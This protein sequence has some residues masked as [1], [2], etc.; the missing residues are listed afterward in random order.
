MNERRVVA[1]VAITCI[2]ALVCAWFIDWA[3]LASLPPMSVLGLF[4]L[5]GITVVSEYLAIGLSVGR[6]GR[7]QQFSITFLPLLAG[8]QLFGVAGG[9]AM[10]VPALVFAEFF[11]RRKPAIR[12]TFNI[13]QIVVSTTVAGMVWGLIGGTPLHDQ[14]APEIGTQFLPFIGFGLLFLG[15]NHAAV[16]LAITLSQGLPFRRVWER[17]WSTTGA[18]LSDLLI[19]PIALA[20]AFLYVQFEIFGILI[21]LLPMLFI[22]RSY[23][24]T[25]R[26]RESNSDLLTALVKAIEIRDPYTSGHS[27]RVSYLAERIAEELGLSRVVVERVKDAALLHD[28]GKIEAVYTE[29]LRKPDDLTDEET[30]DNRVSCDQRRAAAPRS[31]LCPRRR[32]DG[33]AT[34]SR[35]GGRQGLSGWLARG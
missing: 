35:E 20:V 19:S 13:A 25:S 29:I 7:G 34:S 2:A 18:S 33:G 24:T 15:L 16:S 30:P 12:A 9:L 17:A 5:M 6:G 1:Y 22:R 4:G 10:L 21:V 28:I 26:L 8:V 32:R 23:L 31:I 14:A 27:Q 3:A 11:V